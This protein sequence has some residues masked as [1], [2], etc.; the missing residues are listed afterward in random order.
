VAIDHDI[1]HVASDKGV[2]GNA[3]DTP[4]IREQALT[5]VEYWK[6]NA[7]SCLVGPSDQTVL[8]S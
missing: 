7:A 2:A 6:R 3:T 8:T 5:V 1:S 4:T